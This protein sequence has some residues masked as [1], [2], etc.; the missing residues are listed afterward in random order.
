ML[1][2]AKARFEMTYSGIEFTGLY[3]ALCLADAIGSHS[4]GRDFRHRLCSY[5]SNLNWLYIPSMA[6]RGLYLA[7]HVIDFFGTRV[8]C[9]M[10]CNLDQHAAVIYEFLHVSRTN[11]RR[12]CMVG[13]RGM[14]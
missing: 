11:A 1:Y 6:F 2:I 5:A 4:H 7:V 9:A 13:W 12:A 14:Y 8:S 10:T 3:F